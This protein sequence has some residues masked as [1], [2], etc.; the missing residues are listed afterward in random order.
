MFAAREK[1]GDLT[2]IYDKNPYTNRNFEN[3]WITEKNATK[4]FVYTTIAD[5]LKKV[6][7]SNNSH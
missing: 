3:Q 5:R 1:E 2:H 6:S 4:N 7:W